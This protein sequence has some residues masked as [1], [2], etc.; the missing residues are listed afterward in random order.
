[1]L[2]ATAPRAIAMRMK[3]TKVSATM[4]STGRKMLI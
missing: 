3:A 1:M 4:T 2:L